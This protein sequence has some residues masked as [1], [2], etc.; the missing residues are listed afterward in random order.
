MTG[1]D[2][3]Y[4]GSD[5]T[6][7]ARLPGVDAGTTFSVTLVTSAEAARP[8]LSS[9]QF[10]S[11]VMDTPLSDTS[12]HLLRRVR[13][14]APGT[15]IVVRSDDDGESVPAELFDRHVTPAATA[16]A[17]AD[18]LVEAVAETPAPDSS[19][20]VSA[21]GDADGGVLLERI[22]QL[23]ARVDCDGDVVSLL[24]LAGSDGERGDV[25]PDQSL[26][27][28]FSPQVADRCLERGNES[29][30]SGETRT[31]DVDRNGDHFRFFC[32]PSGEAQFTLVTQ[33]APIRSVDGFQ[34]DGLPFVEAVLNTLTDVFFV[35]DLDLNFVY[36]N[37]QLAEVTGYTDDELAEMSPLDLITEGDQEAATEKISE[38]LMNGE[39]TAEFVLEDSDGETM[40]FDFTG[41]VL[42]SADG[43]PEFICGVGRD[44]TERKRKER[45]L[46]ESE[47]RLRSLIEGVEGYAIIMLD[48]DGTVSSWNAGAEQLKGYE[49]S[50]V[51]GTDFST[52]YT[53]ADQ[54]AGVPERSLQSAL[55]TGKFEEDGWRVRADGSR[56]WANVVITP[57]WDGETLRGFVQVTQDVSERKLQNMVG[58][59]VARAETF[60]HGVQAI[61]DVVC[62]L[63]AWSAG[64][65]W[66]P[67][68]SGRRLD[69]VTVD[70]SDES[71]AAP[72][73]PA[74]QFES[75]EAFAARVWETG[76][77]EL[78]LAPDGDV[79]AV[80]G[81]PISDE[82]E[83]V[84]V[85]V[86]STHADHDSYDPLVETVSTVAQDV[87]NLLGRKRAQ[88]TLQQ[89]R[90]LFQRIL[91]TTPV[92]LGVLSAEG[93]V[94]RANPR[95]EQLLG[96]S[97]DGTASAETPTLYDADGNRLPP[98]E[99]PYLRVLE[100]GEPVFGQQV[101]VEYA[102]GERRWVTMNAAPLSTPDGQ[103][104]R[105]VVAG[106]DVTERKKRQ[107]ELE[108][109]QDELDAV[110]D[111]LKRSNRELEEFAYAVS[112][113]LKE[114]LRMISS[115]LGLL[116][117]RY[118][119]E[120]DEEAT[121]F[122]EF[123][124]DG[125]SRMRDRIG[126]LLTYS[127][128]S[129]QGESFERVDCE[130]VVEE[131]RSNLTVAI[132]E[133]DA[134]VTTGSLPTV[135]GDHGQ[136][137]HLFQN[138]V[139]NAIKYSE[140]APRIHVDAERDDQQWVV[141]VSDEGVGIPTDRLD[142]VFDLFYTNGG[143]D[144]TGIGLALCEKIV[145]R[146]GGE[147][148][149]DSTPGEGTTFSFTLD[150]V[151]ATE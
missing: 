34:T 143:A 37:D 120:L 117:R 67:D 65:A 4:V 24:P 44:V 71:A 99:L 80:F 98:E 83:V 7:V 11:L 87:G 22:P 112:H 91:N 129:R 18:V 133:T 61:L 146:H 33:R 1:H 132:D 6:V 59:S 92:P 39:G 3:L 140:D 43:T 63:T 27:A 66:V 73:L 148:W 56:F 81:V 13:A 23:V 88:Q 64:N 101:S 79:E 40:P 2:V 145:T 41:S 14:V 115:Y 142:R 19:V 123:A 70:P 46:R 109:R 113:D 128:I 94:L 106:E 10:D 9:G 60:D 68:R 89:E 42:R 78:L 5:P 16:E 48:A 144:S 51:L 50:E 74:D 110:V 38:V 29:V 55:E 96:W 97:N 139:S 57:I 138:L 75:A 72:A 54:R 30:A 134:E 141:S 135:H 31:F 131:V 119:E 90:L 36:W 69:P 107:R 53:E 52:F 121:E 8:K 20:I 58:R 25:A 62:E 77:T 35:F 122:I 12:V 130:A 26:S 102:H 147:I 21:D 105:I 125:A 28:L 114:P 15:T 104:E 103:L 126:D 49:E 136:L 111:E 47:Q 150:A 100:T 95:A 85:L 82:G 149:V 32:I 84:A 86:F 124:V 45:K 118:G 108:E 137:I 17:L 93:E 116:E 127:R 76:E 151:S